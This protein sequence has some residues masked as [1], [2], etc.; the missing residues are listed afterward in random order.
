MARRLAPEIPAGHP[1]FPWHHVTTT[2]STAETGVIKLHPVACACGRPTGS[3]MAWC[4]YSDRYDP[5]T[6]PAVPRLNRRRNPLTRWI[7]RRFNR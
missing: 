3:P 6:A 4:C 5:A 2:D 1:G 7:E